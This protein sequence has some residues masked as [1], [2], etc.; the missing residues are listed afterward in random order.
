MLLRAPLDR[1]RA[2]LTAAEGSTAVGLVADLEEGTSVHQR[3]V[4]ETGSLGS[5]AVGR[6]FSLRCDPDGHAHLLP[7]FSGELWLSPE[8]S[9]TRL[10]VTGRYDPPIELL[11]RD[12]DPAVAERMASR[13]IERLLAE[14]AERIEGEIDRAEVRTL[15]AKPPDGTPSDSPGS[16]LYIG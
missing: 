3:A 13:S 16:E 15:V 8:G 4:L 7:S 1:V 9:S 10:T 5:P 11:A 2:V 6:A 14:I 12:G